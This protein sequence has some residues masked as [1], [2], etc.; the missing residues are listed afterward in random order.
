MAGVTTTTTPS[1]QSDDATN[2]NSRSFD[3]RRYIL[4]KFAQTPFDLLSTNAVAAL[5][6]DS[7]EQSLALRTLVLDHLDV[8]VDCKYAIEAVYV[9]D[10]ELFTGHGMAEVQDFFKRVRDGTIEEVSTLFQGAADVQHLR[11]VE[12]WAKRVASVARIPG[13]MEDAIAKKEFDAAFQ[14]LK[15][16]VKFIAATGSTTALVSRKAAPPQ[17]QQQ[18]GDKEGDVLSDEATSEAASSNDGLSSNEHDGDDA[19]GSH[20][21]S[22]SRTPS[23]ADDGDDGGDAQLDPA[24][25]GHAKRGT[26]PKDGDDNDGAAR[27]Q[28]RKKSAK[29]G[30]HEHE[31]PDG[32]QPQEATSSTDF[33]VSWRNA[34]DGATAKLLAAVVDELGVVAIPSQHLTTASGM[35]REE[36]TTIN[37]NTTTSDANQSTAT[38]EELLSYAVEVAAIGEALYRQRVICCLGR[39]RAAGVISAAFANIF[40]DVVASPLS[41]GRSSLL[42]P[43]FGGSAAPFRLSDMTTA[44]PGLGGSEKL[45][46]TQ[47]HPLVRFYQ[48]FESLLWKQLRQMLRDQ[49]NLSQR[50]RKAM[51]GAAAASSNPAARDGADDGT[52][53]AGGHPVFT[54]HF[55]TSASFAAFGALMG[56]GNDPL[57]QSTSLLATSMLTP[58]GSM[59]LSS[60]SQ[61]HDGEAMSITDPTADVFESDLET[62]FYEDFIRGEEATPTAD[63]DDEGGSAAA[64]DDGGRPSH[65]RMRLP[66]ELRRKLG[67]TKNLL[68]REL[69]LMTHADLLALL[70]AALD[71]FAVCI[72]RFVSKLAPMLSTS[73]PPATGRHAP[74]TAAVNPTSK[75]GAA[76]GRATSSAAK[77]TASWSGGGMKPT[78]GG[79]EASAGGG[80]DT[81]VGD[82]PMFTASGVID[83]ISSLCLRRGGSKTGTNAGN[84]GSANGPIYSK[85]A[86]NNSASVSAKLASL[87]GEAALLLGLPAGF[88]LENVDDYEDEEEAM[89]ADDPE[90]LRWRSAQLPPPPALALTLRLRGSPEDLIDGVRCQLANTLSLFGRFVEAVL[91]LVV[92]SCLRSTFINQRTLRRQLKLPEEKIGSS[93][94]GQG[95]GG[96]G[97][98]TGQPKGRPSIAGGG[99]GATWEDV[100]ELCDSSMENAISTWSNAL[101]HVESVATAVSAAIC[102]SLTGVPKCLRGGSSSVDT[103][104]GS[105]G[106][107]VVSPAASHSSATVDTLLSTTWSQVRRRCALLY[108]DALRRLGQIRILH[109]APHSPFDDCSTATVGLVS[110]EMLTRSRSALAYP[111]QALPLVE[112]LRL[113]TLCPRLALGVPSTHVSVA[114][115]A[116]LLRAFDAAVPHASALSAPSWA[117]GGTTATSVGSQLTQGRGTVPS[118]AATTTSIALNMRQQLDPLVSMSMSMLL[119]MIDCLRER[120]VRCSEAHRGTLPYDLVHLLVFQA[121]GGAQTHAATAARGGTEDGDEEGLYEPATLTRRLQQSAAVRLAGNVLQRFDAAL[122]TLDANSV[123]DVPS[124]LVSCMADIRVLSDT[125]LSMLDAK[126][127]AVGLTMVTGSVSGIE[128]RNVLEGERQRFKDVFC[129]EVKD[130]AALAMHSIVQRLL[131]HY[132]SMVTAIIDDF[133]FRRPGFDWQCCLFPK[134]VR[135]YVQQLLLVVAEAQGR[136]AHI[137]SQEWIRTLTNELFRHVAAAFCASLATRL[138]ITNGSEHF[139]VNGCFLLALEARA[140]EAAAERSGCDSSIVRDSFADYVFPSLKTSCTTAANLKEFSSDLSGATGRALP[141]VSLKGGAGRIG[142]WFSGKAGATKRL[143]EGEFQRNLDKLLAEFMLQNSQ[144][145]EAL[146]ATASASAGGS[147]GMATGSRTL[148]FGKDL[149]AGSSSSSSSFSPDDFLGKSSTAAMGRFRDAAVVPSAADALLSI[150]QRFL[151]P[152]LR[153]QRPPPGTAPAATPGGADTQQQ[154]TTTAAKPLGAAF[155]A[156]H[157]HTRGSAVAGPSAAMSRFI[158]T[159]APPPPSATTTT[160]TTTTGASNSRTAATAAS[161]G[162]AARVASKAGARKP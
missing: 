146:S 107:G 45:Q 8:F 147:G 125:V 101:R 121:C 38:A 162:V 39:R 161:G 155:T 75:S 94:G 64:V 115:A 22:G 120:A 21:G 79:D 149:L 16:G 1:V 76:Y 106:G 114:L 130:V 154:S 110:A 58:A 134:A 52:P 102:P 63:G 96:P 10:P 66:E 108:V 105:G 62:L 135:P 128:A 143:T 51:R 84:D 34:I 131:Q 41:M 145:L 140:I 29:D 19:S 36:G 18:Q 83:L 90:L 48:Q 111:A 31:G 73:L 26:E 133:G 60:T 24:A 92:E 54:E 44:F 156:P 129:R 78:G 65:R 70:H 49:L 80:G 100:F 42:L 104:G 69:A 17:Q 61:Q 150:Q 126:L 152:Q 6:K 37:N 23:H 9:S 119:T 13:E 88:D 158:R 32:A 27:K 124:V 55:S 113:M 46:G 77:P 99:G 57:A 72:A 141:T 93:E 103:S 53:A 137:H 138:D 157:H 123:C 136:L 67:D 122:G 144:L 95:G 116:L 97:A 74:T 47:R 15:R 33:F 43:S 160:T 12:E 132:R 151:P 11:T 82:S 127:T 159:N 3:V 86:G 118:V 81:N 40:G 50:H 148:A 59:V 85:G 153:V 142:D 98:P 139:R 112:G 91:A 71:S 28:T 117:T 4:K 2:V 35:L 89:L 68:L 25:D 14:A 109:F 30:R 7:R 20:H 87:R 56:K 5:E